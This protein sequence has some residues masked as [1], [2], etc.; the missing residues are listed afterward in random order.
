[1]FEGL[2]KDYWMETVYMHID[3]DDEQAAGDQSKEAKDT[4]L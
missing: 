3:Y 1:M 4:K 2:D